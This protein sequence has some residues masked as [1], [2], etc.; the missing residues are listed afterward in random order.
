[1]M[2][3]YFEDVETQIIKKEPLFKITN[4]AKAKLNSEAWQF[5]IYKMIKDK[6]PIYFFV[7]PKTGLGGRIIGS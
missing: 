6:T 5:S 1:M 3:R 4:D 2:N 7:L